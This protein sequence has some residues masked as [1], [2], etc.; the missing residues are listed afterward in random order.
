MPEIVSFFFRHPYFAQILPSKNKEM[1]GI[2]RLRMIFKIV[3][4]SVEFTFE[5]S[6]T[7][8]DVK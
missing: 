7:N 3:F 8:D 4:F 2:V 1:H 6:K 5:A